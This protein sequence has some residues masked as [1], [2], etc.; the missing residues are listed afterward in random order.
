MHQPLLPPEMLA[1]LQAVAP[2]AALQVPLQTVCAEARS[3]H[4]EFWL[5]AAQASCG[6]SDTEQWVPSG[7]AWQVEE[8]PWVRTA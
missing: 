6:G 3:L 7:L 4:L 1:W 8:Q 5:L 2:P